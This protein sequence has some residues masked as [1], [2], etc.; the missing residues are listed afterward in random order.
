MSFPDLRNRRLRLEVAIIGI[1]ES[2]TPCRHTTGFWEIS[3]S[4]RRLPG[5]FLLCRYSIALQTTVRPGL[6][7]SCGLWTGLWCRMHIRMATYS[8]SIVNY[9]TVQECGG[10]QTW[11]VSSPMPSYHATH[12]I[13]SMTSHP[14]HRKSTRLVGYRV[15]LLKTNVKSIKTWDP[16]TARYILGPNSCQIQIIWILSSETEVKVN[17]KVKRPSLSSF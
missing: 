13:P 11:H 10:L 17:S 15:A 3:N 2:T 16:M 8:L 5:I 12:V 7:V 1:I 14:I 6:S 9:G 4:Q